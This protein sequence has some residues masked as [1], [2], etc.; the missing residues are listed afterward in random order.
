MNNEPNK[1]DILLMEQEHI[2]MHVRPSE[3]LMSQ[4]WR[5]YVPSAEFRSI[6]NEAL[7]HAERLDVRRWFNDLREM[8]A[9]LQKDE[10]WTMED[11]FP[12][13]A[14]TN[15][16]RMAFLMSADYFNQMSVDRI[17]NVGTALMPLAVGYFGDAEEARSW[18][19]STESAMEPV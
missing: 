19:L 5:G 6:M 17:M 8:E 2:S 15:V 11:W 18:L 14:R 7:V 9:I 3:R 10:K 16:A 1:D 13:L 4:T 12:R